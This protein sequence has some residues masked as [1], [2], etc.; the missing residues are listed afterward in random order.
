LLR[1]IRT[2]LVQISDNKHQF[3]ATGAPSFVSAGVPRDRRGRIT[4]K[5]DRRAR[6]EPSLLDGIGGDDDLDGEDTPRIGGAFGDSMHEREREILE[7]LKS[8]KY[9]SV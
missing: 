4:H 8:I 5:A 3:G 7:S 9:V 2:P 1:A 6:Y